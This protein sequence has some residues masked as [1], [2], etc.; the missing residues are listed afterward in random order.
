LKVNLPCPVNEE[1]LSVF[2]PNNWSACL[3]TVWNRSYICLVCVC[4]FCGT[5]TGHCWCVSVCYTG[6]LT[7]AF[8][9]A[10]TATGATVRHQIDPAGCGR[11]PHRSRYPSFGL[12]G[13][14]F[15]FSDNWW[16]KWKRTL[17][18]RRLFIYCYFVSETIYIFFKI[19]HNCSRV[20]LLS[21]FWSIFFFWYPLRLLSTHKSNLIEFWLF[22]L[23][24]SPVSFWRNL[25]V[26]LP[27]V[28]I[29]YRY[30]HADG[31]IRHVWTSLK[32]NYSFFFFFV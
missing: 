13:C 12:T 29:R 32:V 11:R 15:T 21:T 31:I 19:F 17:R 14:P 7:A 2:P 10:T 23:S 6:T 1:T 28:W 26:S 27:P 5:M 3:H 16:K 20:I 22:S 9:A 8:K 18:C 4:V 25:L 30:I 24:L